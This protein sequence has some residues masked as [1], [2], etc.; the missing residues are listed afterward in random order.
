MIEEFGRRTLAGDG[1]LRQ[2]LPRRHVV[3]GDERLRRKGLFEVAA[4][5]PTHGHS[6]IGVRQ[7]GALEVRV[8][9]MPERGRAI[10]GKLFLEN[11][12]GVVGQGDFPHALDEIA[13]DQRV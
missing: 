11:F 9:A 6:K 10:L 13:R 2:E 3:N 4:E 1:L 8:E 5:G 12:V 7:Q